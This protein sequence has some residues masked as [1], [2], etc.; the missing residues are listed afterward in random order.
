M[1][2]EPGSDDCAPAGG[3]GAHSFALR[4]PSN[5]RS[6]SYGTSRHSSL[7]L[8]FPRTNSYQTGL[9]RIPCRSPTPDHH[10]Q[11]MEISGSLIGACEI[12]QDRLISLLNNL[13][14]KRRIV[15]ALAGVPG[16]GKSTI[17]AALLAHLDKAGIRDILIAPMVRFC[18]HT[19]GITKSLLTLTGWLSLHESDLV[20]ICRSR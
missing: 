4:S 18:D 5:T 11:T 2:R 13:P 10:Y 17:A 7:D 12:L 14:P 15:I 6:S 16:S 19:N 3:P 20:H 1:A 8:D 9:G